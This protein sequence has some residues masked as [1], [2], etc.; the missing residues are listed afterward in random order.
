MRKPIPIFSVCAAA[1][2]AC[3]VAPT[4]PTA[5][6]ENVGLLRTGLAV[7]A[8]ADTDGGTED[9]DALLDE[10]LAEETSGASFDVQDPGEELV[11]DINFDLLCDDVTAVD[12]QNSRA[13]AVCQAL[14]DAFD[15]LDNDRD[16]ARDYARDCTDAIRDIDAARPIAVN[17][18]DRYAP[19]IRAVI[20]LGVRQGRLTAEQAT[21][22][23]DR[24]DRG[25]ARL[26]AAINGYDSSR[27]TLVDARTAYQAA[28]TSFDAAKAAL[29]A[30]DRRAAATAYAEGI[31]NYNR[32]VR[33]GRTGATDC[34]NAVTADDEGMGLLDGVLNELDRLRR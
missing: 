7:A 17:N 27:T 5:K 8:R 4:D 32:G 28:V 15:E 9:Y 18:K 12:G 21:A 33:L 23:R 19:R 29:R 20:D 34:R 25:V 31:A 24:V 3:N 13:G 26:T 1:L 11:E 2:F 16:H 22:L 30:G 14:A 10:L 6:P